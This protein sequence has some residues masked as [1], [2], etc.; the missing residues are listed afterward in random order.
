VSVRR[1]QHSADFKSRAVRREDPGG[2]VIGIWCPSDDDQH[3]E[4]GADQACKRAVRAWQQG[5]SGRRFAKGDRRSAPQDRPVAGRTGFSCRAACHLPFAA[6]RAMI[7][8][9]RQPAMLAARDRAQQLLLSTPAGIGGGARCSQ[10]ARPDLHRASGI[11]QPVATGGA[12]A[13]GDFR[14]SPP[15][16]TADA[17]TGTVRDRPKRN[18]SQPHSEHK[19]YPTCCAT[20]RSISRTRCGQPTL[21]TSRCV[22]GFCIWLRSST[23]EPGGF[24]R[25][26]C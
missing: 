25:G 26:V 16:P 20:K 13:R 18:T 8:P 22:K 3:L 11:W 1:K 14:R 10:A 24:R 17:Q 6:R 9:V 2:T 23:G 21:R 19:I 7:A 4:A 15:H 5:A 12:G